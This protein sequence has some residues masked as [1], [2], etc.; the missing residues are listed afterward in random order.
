MIEGLKEAS[1]RVCERD[2]KGSRNP[3]GQGA[4]PR[5]SDLIL[6]VGVFG[7]PLLKFLFN[8]RQCPSGVN[9]SVL[10]LEMIP[11]PLEKFQQSL[12]PGASST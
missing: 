1:Q 12:V 9:G 2:Y 6:H 5:S 4:V 11:D 7:A 8:F 10:V 3:K